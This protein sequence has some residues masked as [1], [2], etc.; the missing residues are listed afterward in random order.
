MFFFKRGK[1]YHIEYFDE[2]IDIN[3]LGFLQRNDEYRI[4]SSLIWTTANMSWARENQFDL[5]GFWQK[6]VTQ[7]L[8]T[9][10]GIFLSDRVALNDLSQ[11]V[12]RLNYFVSYYDDLNSFGNGTYRIDDRV[13][14]ILSWESDS[15]QQWSYGAE[16]AFAE[17]NVGGATNGYGAWLTWRPNDRRGVEFE[18]FYDDR[19]GWLLHQADDLFATFDAKQWVP[20]LSVEYFFSAR[21]QLRLSFQYIG[22]K[23]AEKDFYRVPSRP[24]DL[25][26]TAKPSG[27]GARDSYDF[28]VS[29]YTL[30]ARYRWEIAPLSDIFLVYTRQA[31]LRTALDDETFSDLFDNAWQDPLADVFVLKFRYR[32]GS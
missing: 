27:P 19:D 26:P 25:I 20:S 5:R 13:E 8:L 28:S 24:D 23:A 15:T 29:Q 17:E 32:F 1:I 14:T 10:G 7:S 6:S 12:A 16:Y 3:D 18:V 30:Q 22:I 21:Q 31:D 9:G 2:N 4:R 11:L